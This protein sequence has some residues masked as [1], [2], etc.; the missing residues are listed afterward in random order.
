MHKGLPS[1]GEWYFK[2]NHLSFGLRFEF[3]FNRFVFEKKRSLFGEIAQRYYMYFQAE[4]ITNTVDHPQKTVYDTAEEINFFSEMFYF[5]P[6]SYS[7]G[8]TIEYP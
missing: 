2:S 7:I 5:D 3:S 6:C 4:Y 8:F 1:H